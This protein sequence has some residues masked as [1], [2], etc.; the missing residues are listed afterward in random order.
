MDLSALKISNLR[1]MLHKKELSAK[2]LTDAYLDRIKAVDDK[3][4][5]YITVT[6]EAAEKAAEKAQE[7]KHEHTQPKNKK[8]KKKTKNKKGRNR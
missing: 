8:K 5:S 6:A 2:E 4:E 3:L 1:S 7:K